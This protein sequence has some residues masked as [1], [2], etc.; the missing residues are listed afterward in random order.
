MNV[1]KDMHTAVHVSGTKNGMIVTLFDHGK[2]QGT[3]TI[4]ED[5]K[6]C[7]RQLREHEGQDATI[8]D[9]TSSITIPGHLT[10]A[11]AEA[12]RDESE[13]VMDEEYGAQRPDPIAEQ[14]RIANLLHLLDM[15]DRQIMFGRD[16]IYRALD[17]AHTRVALNI[18]EPEPDGIDESY[19]FLWPDFTGSE[20]DR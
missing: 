7:E 9:G 3:V 12:I 10:Y 13:R 11:L 18:P 4:R 5:L 19:P 2:P 1:V 20:D 6:H 15:D 17:N 16:D 8:A 14:L